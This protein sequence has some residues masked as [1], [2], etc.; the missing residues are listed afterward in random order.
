MR[1]FSKDRRQYPRQRIAANIRL[2][3]ASFGTINALSCDISDSGLFV[4]ATNIPDFPKGA[5]I[6]VQFMDSANPDLLFNTRVVRMYGKGVGLVVVDY[7]YD[8]QRF[9]LDILKEQWE[10]AC[11]DICIDDVYPVDE[12]YN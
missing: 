7:E 10:L 12:L 11:E 9:N 3:H 4:M 1:M 8:G 2:S 5:H 6:N